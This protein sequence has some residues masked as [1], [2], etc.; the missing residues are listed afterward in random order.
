M[1]EEL[2]KPP[3]LLEHDST[4]ETVFRRAGQNKNSIRHDRRI[5]VYLVCRERDSPPIQLILFGGCSPPKTHTSIAAFEALQFPQLQ[6]LV[7]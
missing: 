4:L 6:G 5:S 1:A 7:I 3:V 2:R